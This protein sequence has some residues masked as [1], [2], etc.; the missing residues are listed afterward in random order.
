MVINYFGAKPKY[1]FR[2]LEAM[3]NRLIH[4]LI[5]IAQVAI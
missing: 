1:L 4:R 3:R 5:V 2:R